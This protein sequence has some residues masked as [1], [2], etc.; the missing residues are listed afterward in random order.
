MQVA[1]VVVVE[2]AV[3][4]EVR[5]CHIIYYYRHERRYQGRCEATQTRGCIHRVRQGGCTM[6]SESGTGRCSIRREENI[7]RGTAVMNVVVTVQN[8][9]SQK[10]EYRVWNP[11]RS[12][13]GAAILNRVDSIW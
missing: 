7:S 4:V 9:E 3:V 2:P 12:K 1:V 13:L 6:Y 5:F 11:F 8:A 10:I